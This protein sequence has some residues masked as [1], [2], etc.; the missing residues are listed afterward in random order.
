MRYL[1]CENVVIH[2]EIVFNHSPI[3]RTFSSIQ[4]ARK[5]CMNNCPQGY[6]WNIL[7]DTMNGLIS[8]GLVMRSSY[9][10]YGRTA[11]A[12]IYWTGNNRRVINKDGSLGRVIG[13]KK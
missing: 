13:N 8:E 12:W 5:Y 1:I 6:S 4:S 10:R 3:L 7:R 2:N 11:F 9:P